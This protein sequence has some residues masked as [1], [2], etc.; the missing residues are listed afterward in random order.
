MTGSFR[1]RLLRAGPCE[2]W[3]G[4]DGVRHDL[5]PHPDGE[6]G[7]PCSCATCAGRAPNTGSLW[8]CGECVTAL[9]QRRP[10]PVQEGSA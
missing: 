5:R 9:W 10:V 1:Y 8:V 7:E 6:K 2:R 4:A 3:C